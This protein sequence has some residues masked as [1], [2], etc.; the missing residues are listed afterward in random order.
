MEAYL[1]ERFGELAFLDK[2]YLNKT[3]IDRWNRSSPQHVHLGALER[4]IPSSFFKTSFALVRN[5]VERTLSVFRFHQER[6]RTIDRGLTFSDWLEQLPS[7]R[8]E[9]PFIYDNH[10]RPM[11]ELVP[12]TAKIFRMEDGTADVVDWLDEIAGNRDG[13]RELPRENTSK[14]SSFFDRNVRRK[15]HIGKKEREKIATLY[16]RDFERFGYEPF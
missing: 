4:L 8:E 11:H 12:Q 10:V 2:N 14:P 1:Q 5:P 6:L 3:H 13:P 16:Q 7:R 15:H 9:N